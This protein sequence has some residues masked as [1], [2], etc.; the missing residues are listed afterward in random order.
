MTWAPEPTEDAL[1]ADFDWPRRAR[2]AAAASPFPRTGARPRGGR[3]R[4]F[5]SPGPAQPETFR[6]LSYP[7]RP[8]VGPDE[9][10]LIR[11]GD[12]ALEVEQAVAGVNPS[13][14]ELDEGTRA[15][16]TD[17]GPT[18]PRAPRP[19]ALS[20]RVIDSNSLGGI[21]RMDFVN[22]ARTARENLARGLNALQSPGVPP[23]LMSV[24]EPIAQAMG[25][26]HRIETSGGAETTQV[27]PPP[28]R[29][30]ARRSRTCRL[31]RCRTPRSIRLSR[32]SPGRS[33]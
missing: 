9:A 22:M 14:P 33:A 23:S 19:R 24:A 31:N 12:G 28:S 30:C 26:M 32:P 10:L 11:Y 7:G 21:S 5:S 20:G 29:T 25:C 27:A 16:T 15:T 1:R 4:F 3:F 6:R 18:H 2:A 17:A 8:A 13:L